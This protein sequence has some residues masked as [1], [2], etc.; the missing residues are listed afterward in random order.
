MGDRG[1]FKF[2]RHPSSWDEAA[3]QSNPNS[4]PNPNPDPNPNPNPDPNPNQAARQCLAICGRCPRCE[5][6]LLILTL[7]LTLTLALALTLTLALA[8]ALTRCEHISV[9]LQLQDCSW[10]AT[11]PSQLQLLPEQP[12]VCHRA[13]TLD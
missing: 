1:T 9:S 12:D 4:N 7:A 11:C 6:H 5:L 10:F 13:P 8:L 2:E 3:R